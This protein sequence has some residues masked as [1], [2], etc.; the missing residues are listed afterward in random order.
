[1]HLYA[2]KKRKE[3]E[4]N[5]ACI[6]ASLALARIP[7]RCCVPCLGDVTR[8]HPITAGKRRSGAPGRQLHVDDARARHTNLL[9]TPAFLYKSIIPFL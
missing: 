3:K 8:T 2:Q 9:L 1:M 4:K 6:G 5:E 7:L